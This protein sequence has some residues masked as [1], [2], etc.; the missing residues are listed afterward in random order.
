MLTKLKFNKKFTYSTQPD[1]FN[2]VMKPLKKVI[3]NSANKTIV[4]ITPLNKSFP[5][6]Q[7]VKVSYESDLAF[8]LECSSMGIGAIMWYYDVNDI[9]YTKHIDYNTKYFIT[10]NLEN[11]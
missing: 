7:G 5:N 6:I 8:N 1:M 3:A 9:I 10:K 4:A 11:E 2:D